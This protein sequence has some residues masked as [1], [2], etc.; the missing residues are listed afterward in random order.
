MLTPVLM[1][2]ALTMMLAGAAT[3][4]APGQARERAQIH[5]QI[6][7]EHMRAEAYGAAIEAFTEPITID[8]THALAHYMIGRAHSL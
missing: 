1:I 5:Y 7:M 4:A 2:P 6:G 8:D 3:L